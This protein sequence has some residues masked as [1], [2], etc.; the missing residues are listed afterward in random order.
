MTLYSSLREIGPVSSE[1]LSQT[2][3]F[4]DFFFFL[5]SYCVKQKTKNNNNRTK[6]KDCVSP[7][8]CLWYCVNVWKK[9][10]QS[11]LRIISD[12]FC[13]STDTGRHRQ[14]DLFSL[15]VKCLLVINDLTHRNSD[16][17]WTFG[18]FKLLEPSCTKK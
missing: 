16:K 17:L 13:P 11:V 2:H 4:H 12:T 14:T 15:I 10:V 6:L 9:L 18:L 3:F 8:E 1:K 5:I 7:Q